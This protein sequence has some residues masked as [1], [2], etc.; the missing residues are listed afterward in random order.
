MA[1]G[2][3]SDYDS[4]YCEAAIEYGKLGKS[5]AYMAANF[6]VSRQTLDNWIAAHPEFMDAMARALDLS[7]AWWEDAG[8][9]G[10][11]ADKFNGSVWSRS[12]AAR[13]PA[14]WREISRQ[15]QTGAD[16]GPLTVVINKPA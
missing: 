9:A 6:G 16:G 15:E 10:M 13:F 12:M 1:G 11:A 14:D 3:P 8:Q 7:Q 5:K 2:R 4:A